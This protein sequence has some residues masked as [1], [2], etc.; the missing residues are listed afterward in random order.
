MS[1][2]QM[3]STHLL[4]FFWNVPKN[5]ITARLPR[6]QIWWVRRANRDPIY[7][8]RFAAVWVGAAPVNHHSLCLSL[9]GERKRA[10]DDYRHFLHTMSWIISCIVF[11]MITTINISCTAR[12]RQKAHVFAMPLPRIG[13]VELTNASYPKHVPFTGTSALT[14]IAVT[15]AVQPA[16]GY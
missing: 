14:N 6:T 8:D 13:V 7:T 2:Q 3:V 4:R 11:A 16:I 5:S 12:R 10:I 9:S 1:N 15:P